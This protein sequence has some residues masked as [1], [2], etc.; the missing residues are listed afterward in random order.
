MCTL[1]ISTPNHKVVERGS[2]SFDVVIK[3]G[4]GVGYA[5]FKKDEQKWVK[6]RKVVVLR[7]DKDQKRAEGSLDKIVATGKH[8]T[9]G[10]NLFDIYIDNL[11]VVNY[12][13]ENLNR[14]GVGY[15]NC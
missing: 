12:K 2:R 3:T 8:T 1:V 6:G 15:I 9:Q 10:Y 13:P 7:K 14:L 4:I 5:I 11:T